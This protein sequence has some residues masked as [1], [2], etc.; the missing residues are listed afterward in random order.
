MRAAG[1]YTELEETATEEVS[2]GGHLS[3]QETS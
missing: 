2:A 3:R 1:E